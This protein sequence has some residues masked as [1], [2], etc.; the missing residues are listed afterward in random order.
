[1]RVGGTQIIRTNARIVAA[2]ARDLTEEVRLRKFRDDL[3]Y[4]LNVIPIR[5]PPLRERQDDIPRLAKYFL[6]SFRRSM[7]VKVAGF[8]PDALAALQQYPWPGNVR[9]LRNLVER[10][11][12]LHAGETQIIANY[13]PDP[14]RQPAPIAPITPQQSVPA[15]TSLDDAV[16][17]FERR[18]VLDA[19]RQTK[20]VQTRA[21]KLLGTTRRILN[22][23]MRLLNIR[24]AEVE[25]A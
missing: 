6:E 18:L 12:V 4:R 21:A 15:G 5:L 10:M 25:Q 7:H 8:T 13:L 23:R 1:M 11:L 20:G 16:N 2:T 17:A 14:L 22:Y 24:A 9:E 3:F 19:L